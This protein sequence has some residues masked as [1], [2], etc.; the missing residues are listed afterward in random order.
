M[1]LSDFEKSKIITYYQ[2]KMTF[3]EIAKKIKVS[4][5]TISRLVKKFN[6]HGTL[7]HLRGN[8]RPRK[9]DD[10]DFKEIKKILN[11]NPKTSLRKVAVMIKEK[12]KKELCANTIRNVLNYNNIFAYSPIKKPYLSKKHIASRKEKTGKMLA[13]SDNEIETIIFSDESKFNLK[14]SDGKVSVWRE[15]G[16]GLKL[17]NLIPTV[18]FGG[19]SIMV[20][21]CFSSQGVGKLTV[22]E[23]KMGAAKYVNILANNLQE[24]VDM[25]GLNSFIFQQD[26]DPKHNSRLAKEYFEDKSIVLLPWPAQSPDIN[27]IKNV[28]GIIKDRVNARGP[29]NIPELKQYLIEEWEKIP[30]SL[31]RDLVLN[32]KKRIFE[33]FRSGGYHTKY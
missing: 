8:G 10:K 13:L 21:G 5:S 14:Y 30:K 4:I 24:S 27:P 18:K 32:F 15:P 25:M 28:W 33:V 3:T 29:K 6:D 23:G 19:G 31:C 11:K 2:E 1:V 26:N 7:K 20:W 17:K 9:T 16:T 22:I 12:T